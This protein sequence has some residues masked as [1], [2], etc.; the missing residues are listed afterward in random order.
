MNM[1]SEARILALPPLVV[2]AKASPPDLQQR[3]AD[4]FPAFPVL[5][6]EGDAIGVDGSALDG[7]A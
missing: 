6:F 1:C 5:L 7:E 4:I 3:Y 2:S